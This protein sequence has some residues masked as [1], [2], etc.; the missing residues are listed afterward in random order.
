MFSYLKKLLKYLLNKFK[1]SK[2]VIFDFSSDISPKSSFEGMNKINKNTYFMGEMGRCSY[3]G[4][5]AR[6]AG[7]IGRFTSISPYVRVNPGS[8]PLEIPFATTSPVFF[9]LGK[10]A[11]VTFT[12]VQRYDEIKYADKERKHHVIIGNDCWIGDGAFIVGGIS[13]GDGAIVLANAVV[14]KNIPPY[15]IVGGVPAK[16]LRYRY[17]ELTISFLLKL[18]WWNMDINWLKQNADLMCDIE[19][20]KMHFTLL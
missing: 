12:N 4:G 14:T 20:L 5:N 15:A 8:H 13:I 1:F 19:K 18:Q 9:S 16:I 10:Q 7:K 2:L 3:I 6:I 17:D 11:G